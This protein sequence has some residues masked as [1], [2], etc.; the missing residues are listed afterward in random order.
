MKKKI[1][2]VAFLPIYP[3]TFGSSVVISSFFENLKNKNKL[4]FQI[5]DKKNINKKIKSVVP[6]YQNKFFKLLSVLF[7]IFKIIQAIK[8]DNKN[9]MLIIEGASWIGYSFLT[10][11]FVKNFFPKVEIV[12]RGH[13]VEYEIRKKKNNSI[14]S[15]LSYFFEKFVYLNAKYSTSVSDIEQK[16]I[17]KLYNVNTYLFPNVINYKSYK[18]VNKSINYDY[19]F[20]SGS[21]DYEPN[22]I[23]IDR[24]INKI[25][26]KLIK[27]FPN[28]KLILTGTKYIPYN[29]KWVQNLGIISKS[30]YITT[31]KGSAC[32]AIPSSEGYG[33]RVKIIEALCYGAIVVSTKIGIEG[34]NIRTKDNPTFQCEKDKDFIKTIKKILNNKK[35]KKLAKKNSKSFIKYYSAKFQNEIFFSKLK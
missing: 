14:I 4:L 34:I 28:L 23:V 26:P 27:E 33:T 8:F 12:Y 1:I 6:I 21:Y 10:I 30:D 22:K 29:F 18:K 16:K 17:K 25:M 7:V 24:L 13:S 3:V 31:L 32:I 11:F 5:S 9:K 2:V 15:C 19:I 35:Y 20:Y